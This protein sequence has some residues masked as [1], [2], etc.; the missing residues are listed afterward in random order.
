MKDIVSCENMRR[1]DANTIATKVSGVELMWRAANGIYEG[2]NWHGKVGI[3]CGSGNNAGD[4]YALALI[5]NQNG[6]DCEIED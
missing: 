6:I 4:G 1:S 5:L 2:V 3:V